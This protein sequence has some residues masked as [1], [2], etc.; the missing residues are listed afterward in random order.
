MIK[1]CFILK[2]VFRNFARTQHHTARLE[3][4]YLK[5]SYRLTMAIII[6]LHRVVFSGR[7]N[8]FRLCF[9]CNYDTDDHHVFYIIWN[10]V[11]HGGGRSNVWL[12][13][14]KNTMRCRCYRLRHVPRKPTHRINMSHEMLLWYER[15]V[16]LLHCEGFFV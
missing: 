14:L 3:I 11:R 13:W 6:T 12:Q 2:S 16:I 1:I 4:I 5:S 9:C 8:I 7:L 15:I 10:F